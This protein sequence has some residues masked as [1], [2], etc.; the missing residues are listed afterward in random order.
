MSLYL[1]GPSW[2]W[3]YGSWIYN[4][5]YN[6]CLSPLALWVL[7]LLRRLYSIQHYVIKFVN[8]LWQVGGF[9]QV[10]YTTLCD[11][12]CQWLVAGRWFSPGTQVS[13][14]NTTDHLD[15]TEI[16]LKVVLYTITLPPL[17]IIA[18]CHYLY[19]QIDQIKL[20]ITQH[21]ER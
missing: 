15:I 11:K 4:Y 5:L 13:S 9:L 2:S 3:L 21:R 10:L 1:Q 12:V 18:F 16:L 7:I 8:D 14:T 17:I 6:R 20:W 19:L